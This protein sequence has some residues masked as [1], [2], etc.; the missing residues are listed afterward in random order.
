MTL[1]NRPIPTTEFPNASEFVPEPGAL[2]VYG[3]RAEPRTRHLDSWRNRA[4]DLEFMELTENGTDAIYSTAAPLRR[5][6][7]RDVGELYAL[8]GHGVG[9]PLYLDIT[10]LSNHVWPA[11]LKVA[12]AAGFRIQVMYVEPRDYAYSASPR[13]NVFFDLSELVSGISPIPQFS[14]LHEPDENEVSL[15]PLLGFEGAR[16]KH[17]LEDV[18]PAS[19]N[20]NPVIGVPGFRAEYPFYTYQGNQMPLKDSDAWQDV[21]FAKANCPFS[22]YYCLQDVVADYPDGWFFK[23]GLIGTKPHALGAVLYCLQYEEHVELIYDH[24]IRKPDRSTGQSTC[25]VYPVS[26]FLDRVVRG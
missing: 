3:T 1:T 26:E 19:G 6:M 10:G 4:T 15:V 8:L 16:F 23:I 17:L 20:V 18:Q 11:I 2:Y 25:L 7:L 14:N 9:R 13:E 12:R 24:T 22:L 5:A 21:R